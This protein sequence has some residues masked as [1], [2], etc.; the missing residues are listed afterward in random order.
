MKIHTSQE[1][2]QSEGVTLRLQIMP[3]RIY[4][5]LTA[6]ALAVSATRKAPEMS[7]KRD[8]VTVPLSSENFKIEKSIPN[9]R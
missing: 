2:V 9:V 6:A 7:G 3:L 8:F 5:A 1:R 4:A